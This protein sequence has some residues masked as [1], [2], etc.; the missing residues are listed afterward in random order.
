[1]A[2][3]VVEGCRLSTCDGLLNFNNEPVLKT[4]VLYKQGIMLIMIAM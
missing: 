3:P 1:M 2:S 4:G